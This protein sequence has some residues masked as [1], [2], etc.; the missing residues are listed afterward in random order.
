MAGPWSLKIV[1]REFCLR[2]VFHKCGMSPVYEM[3]TAPSCLLGLETKLL[4]SSWPP[5]STPEL[6]LNEKPWSGQLTNGGGE[7]VGVGTTR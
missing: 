7:R 4:F 1:L 2:L 6:R 3:L 5:S